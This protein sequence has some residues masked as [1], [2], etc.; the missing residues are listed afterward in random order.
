MFTFRNELAVGLFLFGSTYLWLTPAFVG[1]SAR[2]TTWGIVQVLAFVA[3]IGFAIAAWGI[4]QSTAWW[5][6]PVAIGS[7]IIG[8]SSVVP[9][10]IAAQPLAEVN[11]VAMLENIAIHLLGG[12]VVLAALLTPAAERW[13][14]GRL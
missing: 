13:I 14:A 2:G 9:Y 8:M 1:D 7:A 5:W 11:Q 4:F 10:W 12:V 6:E 3:I